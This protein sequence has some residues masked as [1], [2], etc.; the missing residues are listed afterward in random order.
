MAISIISNVGTDTGESNYSSSGTVTNSANITTA[1]GDVVFT[2]HSYEPATFALISCTVSGGTGAYTAGAGITSTFGNVASQA[3]YR[4]STVAETFKVTTTLA[5]S[6]TNR[7]I[8]VSVLRSS[9]GTLSFHPSSGFTQLFDPPAN[10]GTNTVTAQS[11]PNTSIIILG[12]S[13][14]SPTITGAGSGY[15]AAST[16]PDSDYAIYQTNTS[17]TSTSP[18]F[19]TDVTAVRVRIAGFV[20]YDTPP[21]F[22]PTDTAT[23]N[24][25]V[26]RGIAR[27]LA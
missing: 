13:A 24:R 8:V 12:A 16:S 5:T 26:G 21:A 17:A 3:F 11:V 27:G 6:A 10:P 20:F 25:G 2:F 15:T 9:T 23:L 18:V 22:T 19:T 1:I 14:Q 4:I 7:R